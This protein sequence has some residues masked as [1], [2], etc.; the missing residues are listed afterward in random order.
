MV[1]PRE[2]V[3]IAGVRGSSEGVGATNVKH[4]SSAT[5]AKPDTL[6]ANL[7]QAQRSRWQNAPRPG[8]L[9][10]HAWNRAALRRRRNPRGWGSGDRYGG[11][12]RDLSA[13]ESSARH[14]R[15]RHDH[16]RRHQ[17]R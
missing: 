12:G 2:G 13:V 10:K 9:I 15:L 11:A 7:P 14:D 1:R 4:S 5:D 6:V 16:V 8:K 3:E 17:T